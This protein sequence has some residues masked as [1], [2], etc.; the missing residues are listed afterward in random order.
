MSLDSLLAPLSRVPLF[1]GLTMPQLHAIAQ[2]CERIVVDRGRALIAE[3]HQGDAAY[4]IV[5]GRV[6]RL[7][8]PGRPTETLAPGTLVGEMAMLIETE[9][10]ATVV[11]AE[12]VRA[13]RISRPALRWVMERDPSIA[14]H[15]VGKV[16]ERLQHMAADLREID[17][18]FGQPSPAL[19]RA[20]F[21]LSA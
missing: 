2:I 17:A 11:T 10:A 9:H 8:G 7:D 19:G 16:T 15:F 1:N 14:A 18:G 5:K 13:L 21:A 20:G 6:E 12:V 4:L 3:G